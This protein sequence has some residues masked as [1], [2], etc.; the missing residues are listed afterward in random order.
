MSKEELE[1]YEDEVLIIILS[2]YLLQI[3]KIIA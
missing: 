3:I 1:Y 2:F